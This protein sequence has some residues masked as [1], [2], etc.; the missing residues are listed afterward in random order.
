[1]GMMSSL[2][3]SEGF[4][5]GFTDIP[6]GPGK[7]TSSEWDISSRDGKKVILVWAYEV[8]FSDGSIWKSSNK[9]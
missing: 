1:M 5:S 8:A 2:N 4:G 9:K 7:T 6:I 3:G